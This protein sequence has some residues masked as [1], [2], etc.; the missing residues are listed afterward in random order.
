MLLKEFQK[1]NNMFKYVVCKLVKTGIILVEASPLETYSF[2]F[3][4]DYEAFV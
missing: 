2:Y 3:I 4:L 1:G